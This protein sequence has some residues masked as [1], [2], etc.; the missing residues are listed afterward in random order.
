MPRKRN[1]TLRRV[2]AWLVRQYEGFKCLEE[3]TD[4]RTDI[5][6][7]FFFLGKRKIP[8]KEF[9]KV[10]DVLKEGIIFIK[11]MMSYCWGD[12]HFLSWSFRHHFAA[13]QHLENRLNCIC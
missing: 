11:L 5:K 1:V 9:K 7:L 13:S 8:K 12:E 3:A 6:L 4:E 10:K 2:F